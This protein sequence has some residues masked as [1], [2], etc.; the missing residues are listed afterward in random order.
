MF[1]HDFN[2]NLTRS[3]S[4]GVYGYAACC[5]ATPSLHC[6][7]MYSDDSGPNVGDRAVIACP[8]EYDFTLT[9]CN[10]HAPNGR[11]AGAFIEGN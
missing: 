1:T 2:K 5:Q 4:P 10:V 7:T 6:V 11:G 8:A 9:G 3:P